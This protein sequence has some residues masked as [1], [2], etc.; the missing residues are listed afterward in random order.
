MYIWLQM[1]ILPVDDSINEPPADENFLLLPHSNCN[2]HFP[3]PLLSPALSVCLF[4][5][6]SLCAIT[7]RNAEIYLSVWAGVSWQVRCLSL[8]FSGSRFAKQ[9]VKIAR[10]CHVLVA[11]STA[12]GGRRVGE[13]GECS[14]KI[15]FSRF[16]CLAFSPPP[17]LPPLLPP[18]STFHFH[19]PFLNVHLSGSKIV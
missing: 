14:W 4:V 11:A 6:L 19:A 10:T 12:R 8:L 17:P 5:W 2:S 13:R 18:P 1:C 9:T 15:A 7:N 3:T 16:V